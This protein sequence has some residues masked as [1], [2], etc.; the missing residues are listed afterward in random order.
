MNDYLPTRLEKLNKKEY[1]VDLN[2]LR[3][4]AEGAGFDLI[5][6]SSLSDIINSSSP[7]HP[8][9]PKN[10][11]I[12][13]SEPEKKFSSLFTYFI[14]QK[15]T[16]S[17]WKRKMIS[18][19]KYA[20]LDAQFDAQLEVP[21]LKNSTNKNHCPLKQHVAFT[22]VNYPDMSVYNSSNPIQKPRDHELTKPLSQEILSNR[23]KF[24]NIWKKKWTEIEDSQLNML[25]CDTVLYRPNETTP[26][27]FKIIPS[28]TNNPKRSR[29]KDNANLPPVFT[30]SVKKQK[31]DEN[32]E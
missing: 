4:L 28:K 20:Q 26:P 27:I 3:Q 10:Y 31:S 9:H 8:H 13:L 7:H 15:K 19:F 5:E 14:F 12:Q 29:N 25:K 24:E 17:L 22:N 16:N 2:K 6:C 1:L 30:L 23:A 32:L 11:N 21:Q 18:K